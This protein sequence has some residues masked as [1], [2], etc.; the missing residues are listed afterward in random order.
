MKSQLIKYLLVNLLWL[1]LIPSIQA[2]LQVRY[3]NN[4]RVVNMIPLNQ[5]GETWQDSEPNIAVDPSNPNRII[6]SAFTINP[7]GNT[8]SAPNYTSTHGGNT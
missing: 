5:S 7:T 4:V 2:Q 6:G 3:G 8:T 1:S